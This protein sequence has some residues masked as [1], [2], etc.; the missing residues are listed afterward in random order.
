MAQRGRSRV[1]PTLGIPVPHFTGSLDAKIPGENVVLVHLDESTAKW[2]A[3]NRAS[4]GRLYVGV[5]NTEPLSRRIAGLK[6]YDAV[7]KGK[8]RQPLTSEELDA[9]RR[10]LLA[11][12]DTL[13]ERVRGDNSGALAIVR[14]KDAKMH[15]LEAGRGLLQ[16]LSDNRLSVVGLLV[17]ALCFFALKFAGGAIG[18]LGEQ[19]LEHLE[20]LLGW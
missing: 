9:R 3:V 12:L 1:E 4:N 5:G 11:A 16:T 17:P 18:K 14:D 8:I 19:C 20:R 13:I 10:A 7:E 15:E 6:A 2:I